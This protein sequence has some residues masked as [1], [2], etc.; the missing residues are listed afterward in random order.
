[1]NLFRL[2]NM[3]IGWCIAAETLCSLLTYSVYLISFG[4]IVVLQ[5]IQLNVK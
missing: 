5:M 4:Q 1:M 3:Y 2:V